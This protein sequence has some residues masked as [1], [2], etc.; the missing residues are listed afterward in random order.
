LF[1]LQASLQDGRTKHETYLHDPGNVLIGHAGPACDD[2]K[3]YN[4]L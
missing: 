4:E 3:N 1:F 2:D